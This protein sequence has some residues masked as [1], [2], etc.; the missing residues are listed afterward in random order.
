MTGLEAVIQQAAALANSLNRGSQK[1]QTF[2]N[3]MAKYAKSL[4]AI[5]SAPWDD[6]GTKP[7]TEVDRLI[8]LRDKLLEAAA[9][10]GSIV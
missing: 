6:D 10:V 3:T 2:A 8:A 1:Q 9:E 7:A 5:A 4:Q